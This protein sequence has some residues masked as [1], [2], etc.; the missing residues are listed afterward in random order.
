[1]GRSWTDCPGERS[2]HTETCTHNANKMFSSPATP[3]NKGMAALKPL[4]PMNTLPE[5][6]RDSVSWYGSV[7]CDGACCTIAISQMGCIK[8]KAQSP[9]IY[10]LLRLIL[11][12][13]FILLRFHLVS[14]FSI[15]CDFSVWFINY[16]WFHMVET[17]WSGEE[18][19]A[20][21]GHLESA[22][23]Y[24]YMWIVFK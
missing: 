11:W 20:K 17:L 10:L 22:L 13:L 19:K 1:M 3:T 9:S 8:V 7:R 21:K 5:I 15:F 24:V 2:S 4:V 6:E 16:Y 14:S 18:K 23:R 12:S